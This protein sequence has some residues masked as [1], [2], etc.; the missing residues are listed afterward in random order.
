M[1]EVTIQVCKRIRI[2]SHSR[3]TDIQTVFLLQLL[4]RFF[5]FRFH[6]AD[7]QISQPVLELLRLVGIVRVRT[8]RHW[9]QH[10][11]SGAAP[12][13]DLERSRGRFAQESWLFNR[14]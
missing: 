10:L 12:A 2:T 11:K 14:K 5:F 8:D 6:R 9:V 3:V 4:S 1:P 7:V 13:P